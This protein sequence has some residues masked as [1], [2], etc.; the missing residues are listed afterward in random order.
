MKYLSKI[1][2]VILLSIWKLNDKAYGMAIREQVGIDTGVA[3]AS[4]AIYGPLSRLLKN[5]YV[6]STTGEPTNERGGRHKIYY[7]LTKDGYV[8]LALAQEVNN[9]VWDGVPTFDLNNKI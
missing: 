2:E 8:K 4:G 7:S 3:W 1:E 6:A 5:G 9:S